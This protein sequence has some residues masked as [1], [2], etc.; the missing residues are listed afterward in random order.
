MDKT[1]PKF[2][3]SEVVRKQ[4]LQQ[5]A[6]KQV[7]LANEVDIPN[8][9]FVSKM[10]PEQI[11]YDKIPTI[12]PK[13]SNAEVFKEMGERLS[14][15]K[16]NEQEG[17]INSYMQQNMIAV[18]GTKLV[19][20]NPQTKSIVEHDLH[21]EKKGQ[22]PFPV[23]QS[24]TPKK[25]EQK[26]ES[27]GKAEETPKAEPYLE[28]PIKG[29]EEIVR[30]L[31]KSLDFRRGVNVDEAYRK[32]RNKS[33]RYDGTTTPEARRLLRELSERLN[34]SRVTSPDTKLILKEEFQN[35]KLNPI[36]ESSSSSSS[37]FGGSIG[38]STHEV[39]S[40]TGTRNN[41]VYGKYLIDINQLGSG[42]LSVQSTNKKAIAHL[43]KRKIS[44]NLRNA[45]HAGIQ[46]KVPDMRYLTPEEEDFLRFL[47]DKSQV[48][49][50]L[51]FTENEALLPANGS[52]L[53]EEIQ[54]L[55]GEIDVGNDS[56][57]LK[58]RLGDILTYL[59][60]NTNI[61]KRVIKYYTRKYLS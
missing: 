22:S 6:Q 58:N 51:Y 26:S 14:L 8:P 60:N 48:Y 47:I 61:P 42:V 9:P 12:L 17:L 18:N 30:Y 36:S 49:N 45:I 29:I 20:Q 24:S 16:K 3:Y 5:E 27:S 23:E 44:K 13:F 56:L 21:T 25:E 54:V 34:K 37:S 46:G 38:S 53:F 2:D 7:Y 52:R 59:Y 57:K 43:P 32:I 28:L 55:T 19:T 33:T 39:R 1:F 31:P 15:D 4:A 11:T 35:I 40:K 41:A 10:E 50:H